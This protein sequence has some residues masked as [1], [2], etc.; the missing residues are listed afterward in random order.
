MKF[1]LNELTCELIIDLSVLSALLI[2]GLITCIIVLFGKLKAVE[3]FNTTNIKILLK[4]LDT[5]RDKGINLQRRVDEIVDEQIPD[6]ANRD[7]KRE[8][9]LLELIDIQNKVL[10]KVE[11]VKQ[12]EEVPFIPIDKRGKKKN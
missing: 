9:Q 8:K 1:E 6:L 11:E 2:A 12:P 4:Q 5:I 10:E 3:D 7:E